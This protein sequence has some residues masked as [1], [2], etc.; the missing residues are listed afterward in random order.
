[1][2]PLTMATASYWTMRSMRSRIESPINLSM[3]YIQRT[4]PHKRHSWSFGSLGLDLTKVEI[5][6]PCLIELSIKGR[7]LAR[8]RLTSRSIALSLRRFQCLPIL[9]DIWLLI[10]SFRGPF[11]SFVN[12]LTSVF[13]SGISLATCSTIL[14]TS[15]KNG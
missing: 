11:Y 4:L 8:F 10:L 3:S 9:L 6:V 5:D 1:M 7:Q 12:T 2:L 13:I 14:K 15:S